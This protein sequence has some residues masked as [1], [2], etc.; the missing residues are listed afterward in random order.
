MKLTSNSITK[1]L[2]QFYKREMVILD[3]QTSKG[4]KRNI[5]RKIS[6][7]R[8]LCYAKLHNHTKECIKRHQKLI[9]YVFISSITYMIESKGEIHM[10]KTITYRLCNIYLQAN[11]F[12]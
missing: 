1:S 9:L 10:K 4:H 3:T 12:G 2:D 6:N 11:E 7:E 5:F 8:K